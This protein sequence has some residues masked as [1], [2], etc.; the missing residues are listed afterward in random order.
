MII[1]ID[2]PVDWTSFDVVKKIR[3]VTKHKKVGHGGT[4]DPFATG[5]LIIGTEKDTKQLSSITNFDKEYIAELKLGEATNTL[6][7]EGELVEESPVPTID[8]GLLNNVLK[9]FLGKQKQIPPMFSAKKKNG[10]RLYKLARKN[11]EVEREKN[12]IMINSIYINDFSEDKINFS[13]NC[14]KGTYIRVLGADIA[15][16]IGTVGYLV[17]L[18]RTKVGDFD[19]TES[20]TL[21]KFISSWK[22]ITV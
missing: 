17:N 6:D 19:V 9:S 13:V 4:L 20:L 10:T 15:K 22:S 3:N 1:N 7:T 21:E 11:I 12:D 16:K 2:K 8:E 14:S 5:V 18:R